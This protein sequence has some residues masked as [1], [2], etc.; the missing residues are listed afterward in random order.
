MLFYYALAAL[1]GYLLGSIPVGYVV[2]RAQGIDIRQHGSGNIGATN[3]LRVLGKKPG[4]F[5]FVCDALKGIS[6]VFYGKF[7]GSLTS[8]PTG[9][10]A[11]PIGANSVEP[12]QFGELVPVAI[13]NHFV[14]LSITAA[15]AC[16]LGHNFP[17]WLRFKGGKGIAT[18]AGVLLALMP[19][20][21]AVAGAVWAA[22]FFT[23]RY[24][25]VASLLAAAM[26]PVA[27]GVLWRF[28]RA[29]AALFYFSLV[30]AALAWWRH[31]AN[32]QRLLAGTE[33]RFTKKPKAPAA[34]PPPPSHE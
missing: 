17:V 8:A 10:S 13:N 30:A 16:I 2:G 24:V 5:V 28:G 23:L 9:T 32:I 34:E 29:D 31:R 6:A 12:Q 33:P 20:A 11:P 18:T 26:L 21:F 27:V 22:A 1:V 14:L 15:V 3:V 25:S 4:I 19:L 7:V